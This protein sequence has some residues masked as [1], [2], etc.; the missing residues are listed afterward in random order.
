[1]KDSRFPT[2]PIETTPTRLKKL[3][4]PP[5][6]IS[7]LP[8]PALLPNIQRGFIES[9]YYNG[10]PNLN[11]WGIINPET[12]IIAPSGLPYNPYNNYDYMFKRYNANKSPSFYI[13]ERKVLLIIS[14]FSILNILS[15]QNI[16]FCSRIWSFQDFV[17]KIWIQQQLTTHSNISK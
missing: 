12:P 3:T 15:I 6:V 14:K 4:T 17:E 9:A 7:P 16:F 2:K 5:S 11:D 1:M 8:N 10:K 13:K